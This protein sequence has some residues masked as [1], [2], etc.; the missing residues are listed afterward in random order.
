M[1]FPNI[2][3]K[4]VH[5][6]MGTHIEESAVIRGVNGEAEN[7]II[8]DHS[9]IGANVQIICDDFQLGDYSK[10]HHDTNVHGYKPCRIGHNA[11]IGQFCIIDTI[12]GTTVGN[13]CGIGAGS[14]LW[15]HIKFGDEL[16]G[17]RFHSVKN[18]TVGN[19]VW[20]VGHCIISP[21]TAEDRSMAMVGSVVTRNMRYNNVY[22]G[23]PAKNITDKSGPQ[24]KQVGVAQKLQQMENYLQKF[25]GETDKIRIVDDIESFR[26]DGV[27]YFAVDSREYT[28]LNTDIEIGFMK[29]LLPEKAKFT[30][31][32]L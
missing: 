8:G 14:Q 7:I 27:S 29:F 1:I 20:F 19:D 5:V 25:A 12:G 28:K 6:G 4:N 3:A 22:A 9:Y 32:V 13:N 24:F 30:P 15:S 2:H 21:I 11:W 26:T 31:Y 10:I 17:N 16:E 18:L 23:V